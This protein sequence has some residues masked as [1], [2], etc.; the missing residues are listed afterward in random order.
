M[1][2]AP[3]KQSFDFNTTP[4][5]VSYLPMEQNLGFGAAHNRVILGETEA[6]F[7][8]ILNPDI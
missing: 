6:L 4:D 2:N 1:D 8:L 7:H 5:W 3:A